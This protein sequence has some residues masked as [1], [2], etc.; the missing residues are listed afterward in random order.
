MSDTYPVPYLSVVQ[1]RD[2]LNLTFCTVLTTT[3]EASLCS[4]SYQ[5]S[6]ASGGTGSRDTTLIVWEA[7]VGWRQARSLMRGPAIP[8]LPL[9]QRPRH[10]LYGHEDAVVCAVICAE[11]D[12][13][14]SASANGAVLMHSLGQGRCGSHPHRHAELSL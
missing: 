5:H 4:A 12:L 10:L 2:S 11:L 14:V 13:I 6:F 7:V 1:P 3:H 8:M 9:K